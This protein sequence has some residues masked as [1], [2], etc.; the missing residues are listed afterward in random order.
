MF[1][2]LLAG[3]NKNHSYAYQTQ[4]H[5]DSHPSYFNVFIV[6]SLAKKVLFSVAF[7]CLSVC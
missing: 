6:N 4:M 5:P 1:I 3:S 2:G 7:V